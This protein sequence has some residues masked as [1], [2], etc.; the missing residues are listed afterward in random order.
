MVGSPHQVT[1]V[2]CELACFD[3]TV[4]DA[5]AQVASG[6]CFNKYNRHIDVAFT[7]WPCAYFEQRQELISEELGPAATRGPIGRNPF[8]P[9]SSEAVPV[10][11]GRIQNQLEP[12]GI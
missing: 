4:C 11:I 1:T 7:Y 9:Y 3:E 2:C 5:A 12:Y 10:K 8:P 6:V